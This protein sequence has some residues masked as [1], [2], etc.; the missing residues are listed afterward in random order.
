MYDKGEGVEEDIAK[1]FEWYQKAAEQGFVKAQYELAYM[2][3][4][5]EGVKKDIAKAFQ[6]FQ[7]AALQG[8]EDAQYELAYMYEKG[9]GV[10]EDKAKAFE[11]YKKAALQGHVD[12][13]AELCDFYR[14]GV[15]VEKNL[16]L[17]AYWFLQVFV[18]SKDDTPLI[19]QS[20]KELIPFITDALKKH[21]EFQ[22][23][24]TISFS[25]EILV[26]EQIAGIASIIR[27]N[28][29]IE[30]LEI[31][32]DTQSLHDDYTDA[33]L[34]ALSLNTQLT[35]LEFK[36]VIFSKEMTSQITVL[37]TQNKHIKELRE[38][39]EQHPF[40]QSTGFPVDLVN[41]MVDNLIVT[42]L[43]SGQTKEATVK[44]INEFLLSVE[45]V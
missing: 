34:K 5:G 22:S 40:K 32:C 20:N 41:I 1:V 33:L 13:Q 12:A 42:S 36:P 19:H 3:E 28:S 35:R 44:A 17:A 8:D 9:K 14:D 29:C 43:K 31:Y 18:Q 6:W 39:I 16:E 23:I 24:K 27:A 10:E 38:Y 37:L 11:W 45:V 15:I 30:Y 26:D 25:A 4:Q 21:S 7:K 2:Y